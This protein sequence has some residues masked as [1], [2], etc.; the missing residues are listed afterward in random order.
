MPLQPLQFFDPPRVQ[1]SGDVSIH[2]DAAIAPGVVFLAP[3]NSRIIIAGG[4]CIGMGVILHANGGAIEIEAGASLGTGVLMVGAG[5][6]G[7]NACIGS[8][9]TIFNAS[10]SPMQ[11]VP[12]GSLI[13]DSS[14]S[15]TSQTESPEESQNSNHAPSQNSHPPS[16]AIAQEESTA[17]EEEKT[18]DE[19]LEEKVD[20]KPPGTPV[21]GQVRVNQLLF[22]LFPQRSSETEK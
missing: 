8:S 22:S 14:R 13:G 12:P 3:P 5:K 7:A 11:V 17:V 6:I 16:D 4:A 1:V 9:T 10:V 19:E 18:N 2:P 15:A 21:Y 20:P